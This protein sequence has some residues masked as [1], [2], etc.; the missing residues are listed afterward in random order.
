[1][2]INLYLH[3]VKLQLATVALLRTVRWAAAQEG[4]ESSNVLLDTSKP[5]CSLKEQS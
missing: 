2:V 4:D 5:A 1:M 3:P